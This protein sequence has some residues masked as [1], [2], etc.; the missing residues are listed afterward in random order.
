[1][2]IRNQK[3]FHYYLLSQLR[4]ADL[5]LQINKTLSQEQLTPIW[6]AVRTTP[7]LYDRFAAKNDGMRNPL[8]SVLYAQTILEMPRK[9]AIASQKTMTIS[10]SFQKKTTTSL[11]KRIYCIWCLREWLISWYIFWTNL[12]FLLINYYKKSQESKQRDQFPSVRRTLLAHPGRELLALAQMTLSVW[13]CQ[14]WGR[15]K[16]CTMPTTKY[17]LSAWPCPDV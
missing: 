17:V 11:W 12:A 4:R 15:G 2:M 14:F 9:I 1:M 8:E 13:Y 6:K 7:F 16:C 3:S 5:H 10:S